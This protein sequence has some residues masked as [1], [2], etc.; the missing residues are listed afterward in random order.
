MV[1]LNAEYGRVCSAELEG[2]FEKTLK[3]DWTSNTNRIHLTKIF[4]EIETVKEG[5]FKDGVRYFKFPNDGGTYNVIDWKTGDKWS[6]PEHAP[7]YFK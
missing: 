3:I 5:L 1:L 4:Y 6:T 7:Y 2:R